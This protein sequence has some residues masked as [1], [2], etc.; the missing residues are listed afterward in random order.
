MSWL[1]ITALIRQEYYITRRSLEVILDLYFFS[2]MAV[3]VFGLVSLYLARSFTGPGV[4]YLLLGTVLW[5]VVRITQYS[6][7][8]SSLWNVWSHNLSNMFVSP[9]SLAE[10]LAAQ[11]I[12]S[13]VKTLVA[14]LLIGTLVVT[15][16]GLDLPRLGWINLVLFFINLSIFAWSLGLA[17]LGLIFCFGTR[18][19]AL[20]W[21]VVFL[22]QPLCAAFF[23]LSVLPRGL[24][25]VA[26]ALPPTHVF[27]A[28]RASLASP[29][30]NWAEA[31]ITLALNGVYLALALA[32]FL[33]LIRRSQQSGQF[34]KND[35]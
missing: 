30:V 34:A 2:A 21:G 10:Y 19:Q 32:V 14:L 35:V 13:T 25:V 3:A 4:Y 27:E 24:Q 7:T 12:S 8:V 20:A 17:L 26:E 23:P 6:M 16:F 31:G 15:L 9:L 18:I 33:W 11:I 28:A 5:E 22:F 29:A 1:R